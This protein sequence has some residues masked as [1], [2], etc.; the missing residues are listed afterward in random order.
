MIAT[1][2][3]KNVWPKWRENSV[4]FVFHIEYVSSELGESLQWLKFIYICYDGGCWELALYYRCSCMAL[5]RC[6]Q[7]CVTMRF[8]MT[9]LNRQAA[10]CI[11][12]TNCHRNVTL[13][14][15]Q[16]VRQSAYS[17][18]DCFYLVFI[19]TCIFRSI[20]HRLSKIFH[21]ADSMHQKT[22]GVFSSKN[23]SVSFWQQP[24]LF[25]V[26]LS[27]VSFSKNQSFKIKIAEKTKS[28]GNSFI[29][30]IFSVACWLWPHETI[31]QRHLLLPTHFA[32]IDW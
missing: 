2:K 4:V 16:C 27:V 20:M 3:N 10:T 1:K 22:K 30:P 5:L 8:A 25:R 9:L 11:S 32:T 18:N 24:L 13:G 14:I 6:G 7:R 23:Q 28:T 26:W 19:L 21:P 29:F 17:I 31:G 15:E 12:N